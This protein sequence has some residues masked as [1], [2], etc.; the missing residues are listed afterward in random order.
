[1]NVSNPPNAEPRPVMKIVGIGSS[2]GGLDALRVILPTLAA[3]NNLAVV[4]LQ[5]HALDHHQLFTKILSETATMPVTT[6]DHG[7]TIDADRI[8]LAPPR[9]NVSLE[10]NMF[11]LHPATDPQ[12]PTP[13]ID[14]FFLSL[15]R[16][17]HHTRIGVILSGTGSDGAC[18]IQGLKA[19]SGIIIAQTPE[20]AKHPDMP[21]AALATGCVDLVLASEQI[22]EELIHLTDSGSLTRPENNVESSSDEIDRILR[23][24]FEKTGC[25]FSDYK[26][27]T[28]N[29]RIGRR[30]SI[31]KLVD[32]K[33][34][35]DHLARSEDEAT[36]LFKDLLI[37]VTSFFRDPDAF[38]SLE[39]VFRSVAERRGVEKEMRIWVPG[40]A[41]GEEVYSI[42]ITLAK[43]LGERITRYTIQIFATDIDSAAVAIARKGIYSEAS[44]SGIDKQTLQQYFLQTNGMFQLSEAIRNMIVF[45]QHDLL[46]DPPFSRID[47]ISC[48]NVLIYFNTH[49]QKRIMSIFHYALHDNGYLFLGKSESGNQISDLFVPVD[50]RQKMFQ[51]RGAYRRPPIHLQF[52]RTS[53]HAPLPRS[54]PENQRDIS[55]KEALEETL[56]A[57]YGH[58]SVLV[59]DRMDIVYIHGDISPYLSF[60]Q[61][62]ADLNILSLAKGDLK[63]DLRIVINKSMRENRTVHGKPVLLHDG[64]TDRQLRICASPVCRTVAEEMLTLVTFEK[65]TEIPIGGLPGIFPMEEESRLV[66]LQKELTATKEYLQTT[67]EELENTNQ[68]LLSLNEELQSTNEELKATNEELETS[69]EELQ[70]ANEELITVNE[71]LEIKTEEL[72]KANAALRES[73]M[74]FRTLYE[75]VPVGISVSRPDGTILTCNDAY[76]DMYGYTSEELRHINE[77]QLYHRAQ[78]RDSILNNIRNNMV[79]QNAEVEMKRKNGDVYTANMTITPFWMEDK[80]TL[81]AVIRD[82]TDRKESEESLRKSEAA[83]AEAQRI[84]S[85]GNWE[86]D[87]GSNTFHCSDELFRIYGRVPDTIGRSLTFALDSIHPEDRGMVD[88]ALDQTRHLGFPFNIE[89]RII[90]PNGDTRVIHS[91]G[92]AEKNDIGTITRMYGTAQDITERKKAE[93]EKIQLEKQLHQAHKMEAIGT[94]AGGISHDFNNILSII[95][96]NIE[97][98]ALELNPEDDTMRYLDQAKTASFRAKDL[99]QQLLRFSRKTDQIQ[100]PINIADIVRESLRFLRASIPK[101]VDIQENIARNGG[102]IVA[103]PTQI[104]QVMLNLCA[105]AADAMQEKGGLLSVSLVPVY[106]SPDQA[107]DYPGLQTGPYVR[108]LVKDTGEGIPAELQEQI[109]EPFFTTKASGKGTGMGLAMVHGIV[110]R[111]GG[112]I[113][114]QSEVGR[115]TTFEILLPKVEFEE[116]IDLPVNLPVPKGKNEHI[117]LID[118][119]T[120]ILNMGKNILETLTYRV[121]TVNESERAL[122]TFRRA[123]DQF[124]LIITDYSMPGTNGYELARQFLQI[125]ND[126]P[127]ILCTGFSESM[128]AE[129]IRQVGIRKLLLKPVSRHE[130]AETLHEVLRNSEPV[131]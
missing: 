41:T 10:N 45:S 30:M 20:N 114:V 71:E 43:V 60:P 49:L 83:L 7:M 95:L 34:Y 26:L 74:C 64:P 52:S 84:A 81:L 91:I 31:N 93:T 119:E 8:Y 79:F 100:K 121:T 80:E 50:N 76:R 55:P 92:A 15:A 124:D 38:V 97:L 51:R 29:R 11:Q 19:A 115:G 24:L 69:N 42:A 109:F 128:A 56:L 14:F 96:G 2:A 72:A 130:L 47:L 87:L 61:G 120:M 82:I 113:G 112:H 22:G 78:D 25:D 27:T 108:L 122:E 110:K 46:K 118:D 53:A 18:G 88:V 106:L 6:I 77:V 89:Y 107:A 126:I 127:V 125:R 65:I 63:I 67:I 103:D 66:D 94:L 3:G 70:A 59:N 54:D 90:L 102:I 21:R 37:S 48:R 12:T 105:N 58:T 85:L 5:H 62:N 36:L 117:L 104:H 4:I 116:V 33:R 99:I 57:V 13:S 23:V 98:V 75:N 32:L 17:N 111:Q 40:C 129:K 9:C 28:I 16:S 1:M 131:A 73:E 68:D 101:S 35:A 123:P 86:W 44:V 39:N